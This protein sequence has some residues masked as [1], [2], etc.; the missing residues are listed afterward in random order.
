MIY[1]THGVVPEWSADRISHALMLPRVLFE[2]HLIERP[3]KYVS[4]PQALAGEGDAIT[5]DDASY[6]GLDA[7]LLARRHGHAIT[8]FVNGSHVENGHQYF[9]FQLSCMLD[10]TKKEQC[11]FDGEDWDLRR[12]TDRKALRFRLKQ[13]YMNMRSQD[14]LDAL[15][16]TISESLDVDLSKIEHALKTVT[17]VE[18]A[19]AASVGVDLQNHGWS[20]I[21]PQLLSGNEQSAEILQNEDYLSRYYRPS[22]KVFAPPFGQHMSLTPDVINF[23]LLATRD[24]MYGQQHPNIFNRCDLAQELLPAMQGLRESWSVPSP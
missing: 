17:P 18:I 23:M 19:H 24:L 14:E 11:S 3:T 10:E 12:I 5:I 15:V 22:T 20:H 9:P 1:I 21:N 6:A 8:W 16:R 13:A 2:K 7:V 4:I